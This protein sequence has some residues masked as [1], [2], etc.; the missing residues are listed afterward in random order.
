MVSEAEV[1]GAQV[2]TTPELYCLFHLAYL[3]GVAFFGMKFNKRRH[4]CPQEGW[5]RRCER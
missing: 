2:Y 4:N 5:T 1:F 3:V